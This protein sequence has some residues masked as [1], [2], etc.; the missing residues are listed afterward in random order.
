MEIGP[1]V[2]RRFLSVGVN[3]TL[4]D[5]ARLM[6]EHAVG[7]AVVMEEQGPGIITERDVLRAVADGADLA[8]V[9][10]PEYMTARAIT[11]TSHWDIV[12]AARQMTEG[13]FRHLIVLGADGSVE[14]VLSI[15][16][17]VGAL[18]ELIEPARQAT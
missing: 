9:R 7:S 1:L 13:R 4:A 3:A 5:A 16:D 8:T 18:L 6:R 15:R 10:V 12:E 11:A 14:G 17:L 2:S